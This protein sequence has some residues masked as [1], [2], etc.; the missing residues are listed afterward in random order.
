ML[1]KKDH[2]SNQPKT[3]E[4]LLAICLV[5]LLFL[6]CFFILKPFLSSIL[7]AIILAFTLWPIQNYLEKLIGM[8]RTL[9]ALILT[10]SLTVLLVAPFVIIGLSVAGDIQNLALAT[11]KWID[12]G[13]PTPPKWLDKV[14]VAGNYIKKGWVDVTS[15]VTM[16]MKKIKTATDSNEVLSDNSTNN[17][18]EAV[19]NSKSL[20]E[21]QLILSIGKFIISI[22]SLIVKIG[23]AA[24]KGVI[25]IAMSVFLTFF[26]LRYGWELADRIQTSLLRICGPN[27]A[28]L[29]TVASKTVRGVVYGIIGTAIV[30][31]LLAGIGFMIAGVPGAII[32]GLLTFFLSTVPMGPPLIWIPAVIWLYQNESSGWAIFMLIWGIGVSSVDNFIK[33]WLISQGSDLPFILIF[34]G[35]IGGA[36]AFGFIGVFIG[37]TLLAVAWKVLDEWLRN[38]S[39]I[40]NESEQP[41]TLL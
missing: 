26:I 31:G 19:P 7:W 35:V 11:T 28:Y 38:P 5:S 24:G 12:A 13:P 16:I 9:I 8:K 34:L 33:P 40:K 29:F 1:I 10:F 21:S 15:E 32:L 23:I 6:G 17:P 22:K 18:A 4:Q 20:L 39:T 14:P 27:S 37:P 3:I 41:E 2:F 25:E 36:L 30:Q